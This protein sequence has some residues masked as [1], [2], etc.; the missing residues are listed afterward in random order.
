MKSNDIR[1]VRSAPYHPATNGLAERFV[2]TFKQGLRASK[3][4]ESISSKLA[5]F[6]LVYRTCPHTTTGESP[7]MLFMGRNL[8]TKLD[9]MKPDIR[10]RVKDKQ[11]NQTAKKS[12][13]PAIELQIGQNFLAR[14]YRGRNPQG[15]HHC[16][17]RA[18]VV[19]DQSGTEHCLV[20]AC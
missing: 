13:H 14:D 7:S 6:L 1:H 18:T 4:N 10:K 2:Q 17:K 9:V 12:Q 3:S 5:N 11:F 15:C 20:S 19:S 16:T 8:R